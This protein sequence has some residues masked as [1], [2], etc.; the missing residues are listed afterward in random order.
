MKKDRVTMERKAAQ[1]IQ[2]MSHEGG[3]FWGRVG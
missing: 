1:F 2:N 3:L